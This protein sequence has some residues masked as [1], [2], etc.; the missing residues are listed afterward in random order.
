MKTI[1]NSVC[2]KTNTLLGIIFLVAFFTVMASAQSGIY[3][4][5]G[6]M[7]MVFPNHSSATFESGST[8]NIDAAASIGV[9]ATPTFTSITTSGAGYIAGQFTWGAAGTK[10]TGTAAGA[11][12]IPGAFSAASVA[13]AGAVSGTTADF[14][15]NVHFGAAGYISTA[16]ASNGNFAAGGAI[17]AVGAITAGAAVSGTS[18]AAT[19]GPVTVYSRTKL[20]HEALSDTYHAGDLYTCS[21]CASPFVYTVAPSVLIQLSSTTW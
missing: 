20:Q 14:S 15:G 21:D 19:A 7:E 6:G 9:S 5:Q 11:L 10:S 2:S 12:T 17:S 16:T 1:F 13:S 3:R 8:L 4:A 18:V